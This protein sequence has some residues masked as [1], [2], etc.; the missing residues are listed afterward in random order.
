MTH[1]ST[2]VLSLLASLSAAQLFA[3][4]LYGCG[5]LRRTLRGTTSTPSISP[6][7]YRLSMVLD[8]LQVDQSA[9]ELPSVNRLRCLAGVLV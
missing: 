1:E 5:V 4:G 7:G 6:H 9:G 3:A 2:S 8:V